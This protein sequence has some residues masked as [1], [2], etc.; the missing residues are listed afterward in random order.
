MAEATKMPVFAINKFSVCPVKP[1]SA[2]NIDMVKANS[3]QQTDTRNLAKF[4][5]SRQLPQA[6]FQGQP[7]KKQQSLQIYPKPNQT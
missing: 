3:C 4:S 6:K 2:I 5:I 1:S 7:T